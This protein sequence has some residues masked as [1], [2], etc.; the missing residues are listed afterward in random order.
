MSLMKIDE[1]PT[2]DVWSD[3]IA[4]RLGQAVRGALAE[5]GSATLILPGGRTAAKVFPKIANQDVDWSK[6]MILLSDERW[7]ATDH[8]DSNEGLVRRFFPT[9]HITGYWDPQYTDL[10][11]AIPFLK[12]RFAAFS[13]PVDAALVGMGEDGHIASLFPGVQAG[14]GSLVVTARPDHARVS[15]AP[16]QLA[17]AKCLVLAFAGIAK[18]ALFK[19]ALTSGSKDEFPVCHLFSSPQLQV[20]I[21][22][23]EL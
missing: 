9:A 17:S 13:K 20:H 2:S 15:L 19:R 11:R 7:V 3:E 6:V 4:R 18:R 10:E 14:L 21:C 22:D 23:S 1:W 8:K 5:K 12:N 16:T